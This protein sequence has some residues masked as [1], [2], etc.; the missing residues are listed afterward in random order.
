MIFEPHRYT[1]TAQLYN[2]FIKVLST[3]D[4][5]LLFD[6]YPASELPIKGISSRKL[7]ESIKQNGHLNA[8]HTSKELILCDIK[9]STNSFDILVTQGAGSIS[10]ICEVI[11]KK[12][13]I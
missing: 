8:N 5:L 6:I 1:R 4:T 7:L 10:S 13:Q 11:K 3:T 9:N 2:D 12:W